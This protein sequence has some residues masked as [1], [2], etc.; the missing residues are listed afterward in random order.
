M[1]IC[2]SNIENIGWTIG[3]D[4][5][6]RCPHC[7][8]HIVR[9]RGRNLEVSDADRIVTQLQ[10][11]GVKTVNLGGNEPIYT[12]GS[13]P[14]KTI[15]PHI[16]RSLYEA[17]IA[18]GLTTA[19]ITLVYLE[20]LFPDTI[21]ML[22]DIDISL[23]SPFPDEHNK[24]RGAPLFNLALKAIGICREYGV[25]R[26]IIMCG[27]RWNL[28]DR[29][30]NALIKFARNHKALIRINFMKPTEEQHMSLVP[31]VSQFYHACQVLFAQCK[32][33]EMGEPL[34]S[35]MVGESSNGCPCGT[36]SFRIHSIDPT[37]RVPVSPCVY[38]HNYRV[39]DLLKDE[40][41][42][43]IASAQF[44]LFRRRRSKPE[45]IGEC[46]G[47]TYLQ[48]CRGG[49]TS[50]SY[51]WSKF[52]GKNIPADQARDPYCLREFKGEILSSR[53]QR[54]KQDVV[55]VHRDYLCTLIVDPS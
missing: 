32:V 5:P 52:E 37:G 22:N 33:V 6:Y 7:Y 51:L 16:I 3:N 44:E 34:G 28:S 17:K 47:C 40:L 31:D 12:S 27:M 35:T 36:K 18:V 55:L 19:G 30:L 48:Q 23:D 49:C 21:A 1:N 43:I 2:E 39:G 4:C 29:H 15:L 41:S 46:D 8:S 38:A 54:T 24:N 10:K 9:N 50:R 20:R 42:D 53:P 11:I 14:R 26:T 45:T 25:E 13:D